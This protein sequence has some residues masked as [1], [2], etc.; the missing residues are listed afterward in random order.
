[1]IAE[2]QRPHAGTRQVNADH[3]QFLALSAPCRGGQTHITHADEVAIEP[4][5]ECLGLSSGDE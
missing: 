1:M 4:S 3:E 5:D 2:H